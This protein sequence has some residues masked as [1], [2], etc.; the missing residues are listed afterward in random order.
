MLNLFKRKTPEPV[1]KKLT[2]ADIEKIIKRRKL[3]KTEKDELVKK[4]RY[5]QEIARFKA[6]DHLVDI[7]KE[8]KTITFETARKT[9]GVS[10]NLMN[11][12]VHA[13]AERNIIYVEHKLM[14]KP[15]I[16]IGKM[17]YDLTVKEKVYISLIRGDIERKR[18]EAMMG[19][20]TE[21]ARPQERKRRKKEEIEKEN[22]E[23][24]AIVR[25]VTAAR[26]E[27]YKAKKEG[28]AVQIKV[29]EAAPR[30]E[31]EK[32]LKEL[33]ESKRQRYQ[34][35]KESEGNG[36]PKDTPAPVETST[37]KDKETGPDKTC[38]K[39]AE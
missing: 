18:I 20:K 30:E 8:N 4:R 17:E 28:G 29:R 14:G 37:D 21:T 23:L 5:L 9:L 25:G 15:V 27:K 2:R 33:V 1:E 7:V 3:I 32:V 11:D 38:E 6:I 26:K 24:K 31:V 35:K 39:P 12:F 10:D 13:L 34:K 19:G 16:R 22:E 36:A